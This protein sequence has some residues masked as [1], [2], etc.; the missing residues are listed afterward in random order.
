VLLIHG[1]VCNRAVWKPFLESGLL[2]GCNTA[3]LNLA[4]VFCKI[5]EYADVVHKAV[6]ELRAAT[7][8]AQVVLVCHSMGGLAARVYLRKH[9]TG[10]VKRVVTVATPHQGTVFGHLG[11]GPN[12]RQMAAGSSF[13]KHLA[14]HEDA[15]IRSRFVCIATRDDNLV[16]P[17]SSPL[18]EGAEQHCLDGVGHLALIADRRTWQL[19]AKAVEPRQGD[20]AAAVNPAGAVS[21]VES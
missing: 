4:P 10:S 13:L 12:G 11:H 9:G 21:A 17:R 2:D 1:Y 5:E 14:L 18:L 7:G 3:T 8:A 20:M 19:I 6:G 15:Q 16:V